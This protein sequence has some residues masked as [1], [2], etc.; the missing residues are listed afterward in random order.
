MANGK[1]ILFK[2]GEMKENGQNMIIELYAVEA[3]KES[4]ILITGAYSPKDKKRFANSAK[5]AATTAKL[6]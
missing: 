1:K 6:E 2:T 5:K 4:T 3:T